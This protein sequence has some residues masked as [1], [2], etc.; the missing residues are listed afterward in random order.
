MHRVSRKFAKEILE[1]MIEHNEKFK[2]AYF[3]NPPYIAALRRNYETRN[4]YKYDFYVILANKRRSVYIDFTVKC[5]CRRVYVDK[6]YK[7]DGIICTITKLKN[8]SKLLK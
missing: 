1:N 8:F 6:I 3:F 7:L 5:S 2:N 4:S